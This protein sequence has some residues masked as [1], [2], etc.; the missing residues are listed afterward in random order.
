MRTGAV[1]V[2]GLLLASVVGVS[3]CE[4]TPRPQG[5]VTAPSACPGQRSLVRRALA[6]S[7]LRV[8]VTGDG[9]PDT[10]AAASDAA[11]AK[12]CR[13]LVAVRAHGVVYSA[14]LIPAA[15][16]VKG[17]RARVV[18]VPRLG[19]HPGAAIVVDTAAM[20]D[21]VRAQLFAY[22]DGGLHAVRVPGEADGAFIVEGGGVMFP[23]AARCTADR[24]L[25]VS[26][27]TQTQHGRRFRVTRRVYQLDR[28]GLR[29]TVLGVRRAN[30][31]V[32]SLGH[33]FPEFGGLH[34][35][36]CTGNQR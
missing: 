14:H 15:V 10:V 31:P 12:P 8:D 34:W 4:T 17:V 1:L 13:G 26:E 6:R 5:E 24:R 21:A 20:V 32:R 22:S 30:L 2:A 27:A 36:A 16:P 25:V 29:L 18:G 3:G 9:K 19:A 7:R 11:A 33:R 35:Q 23:H 28:A